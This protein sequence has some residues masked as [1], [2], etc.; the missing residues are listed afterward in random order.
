MKKLTVVFATLVLMA[1]SAAEI[2]Q[3]DITVFGMD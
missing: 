3:I 2:R 1:T